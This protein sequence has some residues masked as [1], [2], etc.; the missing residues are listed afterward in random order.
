M[1]AIL[2]FDI[3]QKYFFNKKCLFF[4]NVCFCT[5]LYD[6]K[7]R[8][9]VS[10]TLHKFALRH[11]VMIVGHWEVWRWNQ[12][13][14][15]FVTRDLCMTFVGRSDLL[16][17]WCLQSLLYVTNWLTDRLTKYLTPWSRVVDKLIVPQPVK[18]LSAFCG[19]RRFIT[20]FTKAC[21]RPYREPAPVHAPLPHLFLEDV[22][23]DLFLGLSSGHVPLGFPPSI[24]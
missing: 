16:P 8:G 6:L 23:F 24:S 5:L 22:C 13:S 17:C 20:A 1:A 14:V 7:I 3:P 12:I 2:L 19:T 18:K 15:K 4:F 10:N 9:A 21:P 11:V